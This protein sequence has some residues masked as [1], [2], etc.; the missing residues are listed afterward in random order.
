MT[1]QN[2][3]LFE[4]PLRPDTEYM[5]A[6]VKA[7]PLV[8]IT[9]GAKPFTGEA[10]KLQAEIIKLAKTDQNCAGCDYERLVRAQF[11]L[12]PGEKVIGTGHPDS[13]YRGTPVEIT[14]AEKMNGRKMAQIT[15]YL[16]TFGKV[17]VV[18]P[19]LSRR[20]QSTLDTIGKSAQGLVRADKK[21]FDKLRI[22]ILTT[23]EVTSKNTAG[24][25]R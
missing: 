6:P 10:A 16:A 14:L 5:A 13:Q 2:Q 15:R 21:K 1:L 4:A 8:E 7:P 3:W 18:T 22:R 24:A 17:L 25:Y 11:R 20:L 19:N 23:Q 12:K 9:K